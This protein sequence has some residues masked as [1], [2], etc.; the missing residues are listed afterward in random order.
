MSK[1]IPIDEFLSSYKDKTRHDHKPDKKFIR[2]LNYADVQALIN[3]TV[4]IESIKKKRER[5]VLVKYID[6]PINKIPEPV[7]VGMYGIVIINE[8]SEYCIYCPEYK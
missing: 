1:A 5:S 6:A 3:H 7:L 2:K 8:K 4:T